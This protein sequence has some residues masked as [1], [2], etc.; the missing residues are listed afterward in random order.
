MADVLASV[1]IQ[2]QTTARGVGKQHLSMNRQR[3][4][5]G[6]VRKGKYSTH[7]ACLFHTPIQD[8]IYP[9]GKKNYHL[10]KK[11]EAHEI[12]KFGGTKKNEVN[13][14]RFLLVCTKIQCQTWGKIFPGMGKKKTISNC[15]VHCTKNHQKA[16]KALE[17]KSIGF[18]GTATVTQGNEGSITEIRFQLVDMYFL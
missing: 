2:K 9:L 14:G 6:E 1:R 15:T 11:K 5:I 3:P 7:G 8:E 13:I 16:G 4:E 12:Y 18:S 17:G 10:T